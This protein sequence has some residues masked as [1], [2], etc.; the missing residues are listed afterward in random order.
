MFL[1]N[2]ALLLLGLA[3]ISMCV[4][5]FIAIYAYAKTAHHLQLAE[6]EKYSMRQTVHTR[7]AEI[8]EESRRHALK[9]IEEAES[10][11]ADILKDADLFTEDA[12]EKLQKNLTDISL[13]QKTALMNMSNSMTDNYKESVH[14]IEENNII[15]L[16]NMSKDITAVI[17]NE[18]QDFTNI[19]HQET[20]SSQ[21]II[22]ERI[23]A[24]YQD[25]EKDIALY[26]EKQL[27]RV[28]S[29]MYRLMQHVVEHALRTSLP[30]DVQERLVLAALAEAKT[31]GVI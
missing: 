13:S 11:A 14:T 10:K 7:T 4:T 28:T 24:A 19:L 9:I 16:K 2:T 17:K 23:D 31:R 22:S 6:H 25:A 20:T 8:K 21:K 12:R 29:N 27:E 5:L 30:Q 1:T 18:L 26:K 15:S 3:F